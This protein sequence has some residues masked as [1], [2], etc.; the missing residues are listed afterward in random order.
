ML[1]QLEM[2]EQEEHLRHVVQRV[3]TLPSSATR[4]SAAVEEVRMEGPKQ[5]VATEAAVVDGLGLEQLLV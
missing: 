5:M 2:E 1:S 4:D 3:K